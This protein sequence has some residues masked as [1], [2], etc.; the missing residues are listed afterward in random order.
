MP[1]NILSKNKLNFLTTQNF[2]FNICFD[3][4]DSIDVL[5]TSCEVLYLDE[6]AGRVEIQATSKN[7]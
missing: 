5:V 3:R 4:V 1:E 6:P 2:I 7:I